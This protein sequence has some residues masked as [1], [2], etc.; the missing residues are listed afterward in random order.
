MRHCKEAHQSLT[1]SVTFTRVMVLFRVVKFCNHSPK[2]VALHKP[3]EHLADE[4]LQQQV[5]LAEVSST[6]K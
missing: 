1:E 4:M 3:W 5:F 2:C 6:G